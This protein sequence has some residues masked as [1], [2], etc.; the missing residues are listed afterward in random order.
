M[1][2]SKSPLLHNFLAVLSTAIV[3]AL[4]ALAD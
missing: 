4:W 1:E 3:T 2:T